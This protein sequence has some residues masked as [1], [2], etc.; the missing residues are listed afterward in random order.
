M[1]ASLHPR[2]F[3]PAGWAK[4]P[5]AQTLFARVLRAGDDPGMKRERWETPDGDFLDVDLG[6]LP[7]PGAPAV[8]VVHG[9]EG[10][11]R[12]RY[13]LGT[14][15][16]L[17]ARGVRPVAINL[18]GCS[19]VPNRLPRFYH[20][21]ETGDLR[22]VLERMR[23]THPG[24]PLG[25]FGFSLG[26]NAVLKMLG[27]RRDGGVTLVDAAVAMSVPFDLAAGAAQLERSRMGH[28]YAAYFLRSLRRKVRGKASLLR[29]LV[30]VGRALRARTIRE[31]DDAVTAPLH[32]FRDAGAYYTAS[33]STRFIGGI[34][35]P[36]LVLHSLDDPFLPPEAVPR[37]ALEANPSVVPILPPSGGHVGFLEG[38]PWRPRLWG[39]EEGARFLAEG[40]GAAPG[41]PGVPEHTP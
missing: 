12:R 9:L 6:P 1:T 32:G 41:L 19:G 16:E 7:A 10:S 24:A 33:S 22:F 38:A 2:V 11:A 37:S 4:G 3:H 18:R 13:V 36:T 29:P 40:L 34:R 8:L 14:C 35:V 20:S 21:G 26:G 31:F 23:A 5:H 17:L 30:D 39:D 15:R 28:L 27:E 25:V